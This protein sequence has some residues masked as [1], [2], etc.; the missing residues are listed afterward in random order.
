[1]TEPLNLGPRA[2]VLKQPLLIVLGQLS[3]FTPF[4]PVA[5]TL[6]I[7]GVARF[8][9]LDP[10]NL[11]FDN[12]KSKSNEGQGGGFRRQ[13]VMASWLMKRCKTPLVLANPQGWALTE[14]G[15]GH[16]RK[17]EEATRAPQSPQVAFVEV[18]TAPDTPETQETI[19]GPNLTAQWFERHLAPEGGEVQSLLWRMMFAGLSRRLRVSVRAGF[20]EDHLNSFVVRAIRRDSFA[21]MLEG[22]EDIPYSK[23]VAYCVNSGRTDVRDMGTN[24]VCRELY[25]AQTERECGNS[26]PPAPKSLDTDGNILPPEEVS[27]GLNREFDT[28]WNRIEETFESRKPKYR[29]RYTTVLA[30]RAKGY[31]VREIGEHLG[32]SRNRTSI[33]I[34]EARAI[35]TAK[36]P[37]EDW[38][39]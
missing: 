29:E 14:V 37:V 33:L 9:G 7:D 4:T 15:V 16:A 6:C 3:G 20:I 19:S 38:L 21:R 11:P 1:M 36:G 26:P 10:D 8:L 34:R 17:A 27:E 32:L 35:L 39:F 23:V 22:G 5:P 24:P 12:P 31:S 2:Q 28:I 30:M 13:V 18:E 25:G